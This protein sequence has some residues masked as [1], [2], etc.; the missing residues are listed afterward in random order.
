MDT[1]WIEEQKYLLDTYHDKINFKTI[2]TLFLY[3]S[4]NHVIHTEKSTLPVYD[5]FIPKDVILENILNKKIYDQKKFFL[6]DILVFNIP[7]EHQEISNF[8]TSNTFDSFSTI[9]STICDIHIPKVLPILQQHS[10]ISFIFVEQKN[11]KITSNK[12]KKVRFQL[13]SDFS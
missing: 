5:D 13:N 7:I 10:R 8:N 4:N 3:I 1:S 6:K 2:N 11:K 9:S 12:T